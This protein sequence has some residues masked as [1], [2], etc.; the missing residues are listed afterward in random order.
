MKT[1]PVVALFSLIITARSHNVRHARPL[2]KRQTTI[3]KLPAAAAAADAAEAPT[4]AAG[5]GAVT[6]PIIPPKTYP[7]GTAPP[8]AGAPPLPA[9]FTY[10][11]SEWPTPD[12]V[13][14]TSTPEVQQWMKELEGVT[15]P[16]L[17]PTK[18][19]SCV[20]D[21]AAANDAANRGWWT[22]GGYL[23]P[24][25]IHVCPDKLDWGLNFDDGPAEYTPTLLQ[26]LS[27]QKLHATFFVVGSRVVNYPG[28]LVDEYMSGHEISIHT[29]SHHALTSLTTEQVVAELGWT[30]KAIK[31]VTGVTPL[32]MRPPFGDIDDRVRAI[33]L[34]MGLIP[35][36]WTRTAA[37]GQ[38][39]SDDW[40][41]AAGLVT[42][43]ES[44]ETF[45]TLLGNGSTMDTGVIVLQH[46]IQPQ[47]IDLAIK[48]FLPSVLSYTPPFKMKGIGECLKWPASDFYLETN[49]NKTFPKGQAV[50]A[51][52]TGNTLGTSSNA[53]SASNT[54]STTT[55]SGLN[56]TV[57]SSVMANFLVPA[58]STIFA[59]GLMVVGASL[60]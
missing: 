50:T 25:D 32:T 7:A 55:N 35:I 23:R 49:T 13:P 31:A 24:T 26:Y 38:F 51:G 2:H 11:A 4:P 48:T 17:A 47:T 45:G 33:S 9:P 34:A 58:I 19:G 12:V 3:A 40:Q 42:A 8:V 6:L 15:I 16:P 10:V 22:C 56:P 57:S 36:I 1:L 52:P 60:A 54:N 53:T 43:A 46:D 18:D 44:I 39:D 41:V 20:N 27:A 29:W 21:T 37:A 30:R 14:E 5:T 59:T 28:I